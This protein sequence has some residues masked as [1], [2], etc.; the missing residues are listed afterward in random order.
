MEPASVYIAFFTA[1]VV[2]GALFFFQGYDKIF[3][4]GP[5][6][7]YYAVSESAGRRGV[8]DWLTW[9]SIYLSSYLELIGGFLLLLGLF[10]TPVLFVLAFHLCIVSISF[11]FLKGLWEAGH[12]FPRLV[13]LI[14]LLIFPADWNRWS[15]DFLFQ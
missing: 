9:L 10:T 4:I 11:G 8:P 14:A 1:R 5:K 12:V 7:T 6:A 15:L 3:N 13:L 2:L